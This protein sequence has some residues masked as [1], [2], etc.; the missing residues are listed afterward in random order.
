MFEELDL[1]MKGLQK[2]KS[3]STEV[4]TASK[5]KEEGKEEDKKYNPEEEVERTVKSH[6]W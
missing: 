5:D 2:A 6:P 1:N 4:H 3:Q